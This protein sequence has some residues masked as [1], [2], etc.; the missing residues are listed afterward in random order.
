[1]HEAFG[2]LGVG[3]AEDDGPLLSDELGAPVVDV[4][5]G[6]EPDAGVTVLVVVVMRVMLSTLW[7]EDFAASDCQHHGEGGRVAAD[8]VGAS[9]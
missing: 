2:V 9:G 8:L 5:G 1:V 6:V 3:G 7:W 4:G